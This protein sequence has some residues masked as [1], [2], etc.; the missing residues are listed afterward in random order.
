MIR[1][2]FARVS[3]GYI[4]ASN[5]IHGIMATGKF[6]IK[7]DKAGK[8]RFNLLASNG[9]VILSSEAYER[10]ASCLNGVESVRKHSTEDR[11]FQRTIGAKGKYHFNLKAANGEIIGTSQMY[12]SADGM[13]NGIESVR[14]NAPMATVIGR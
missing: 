7:T 12:E 10:K 1:V 8:F 14:M 2:S 9:Q 6:E 11:Y 4:H 13:E 3:R 5:I